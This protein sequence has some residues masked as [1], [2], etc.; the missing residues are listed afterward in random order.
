MRLMFQRFDDRSNPV[1]GAA[2]TLGQ[3]REELRA[4]SPN[5]GNL[6]HLEALPKMLRYDRRRAKPSADVA[7]AMAD[8]HYDGIVLGYAN[9]IQR[10]DHLSAEVR[11]ARLAPVVRNTQWLEQT[12]CRI[13]ALGIGIQDRLEPRA[14]AIDPRLFALLKLLNDRAE[15]FGVRGAQTEAWLHAIGMTNA[16]ALGCPSMFVYPRNV[17][18]IRSP[19]ANRPLRIATAGHLQPAQDNARFAAI[20]R[21]GR[22]FATSY[23]FQNDFYAAFAGVDPGVVIF[24]DATGEVSR[25]KVVEQGRA[26]GLDLAFDDYWLFRSTEKWRGFA[27]GK[28]AYFGDRFHGGVIFLQTGRPAIIIQNDD[29]VGELTSFCELPTASTA[30]ILSNDPAQVLRERLA[31]DALKAM[32]M[33][34]A[35]RYRHFHQTLRDADLPL[36]NGI[37]PDVID[38]MIG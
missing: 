22:T 15:I 9:M 7:P 19:V 17:M 30:E 20:E 21:I 35:Q 28:D 18:S 34:Y 13:F 37:D 4:T 2:E 27:I 16:R 10:H 5:V 8:E 11:D 38:T 26:F 23:V 6:V 33:T 24:N 14:D 12:R 1:F 29:R 31:P 36:F 25:D 3:L 32:R